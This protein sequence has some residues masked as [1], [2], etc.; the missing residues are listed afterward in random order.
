MDKKKLEQIPVLEDGQVY[1]Y[2][3][4]NA[5]Q[6]NIKIGKTKNVVQRLQSLS[7][8]NGAGNK[9]VDLW[10]SPATWLHNIEKLCH[11]HFEYARIP[12]TE[13]F[14]GN[15]LSFDNVVKYVSGLFSDKNYLKC[16][17]MKRKMTEE[18]DE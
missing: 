1:I 13:W 2:V 11:E 17:E 8:S 12:K 14:E 7:G 5:P 18:K 4:L 3:I 9:I 10:V 6:G 15:K 16:N